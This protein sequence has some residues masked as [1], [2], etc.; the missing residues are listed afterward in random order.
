LP[1]LGIEPQRKLICLQLLVTRSC[2]VFD[3]LQYS[4]VREVASLAR[5]ITN[6]TRDEVV[7]LRQH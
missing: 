2:Q 1:V 4:T 3:Y 7:K 6:L 5:R